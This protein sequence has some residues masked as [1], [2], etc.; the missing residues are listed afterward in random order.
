M[1]E[2]AEGSFTDDS[3]ISEY[4]YEAVYSL[5]AMDVISGRDTGAFDPKAFATREETAKIICGVIEFAVKE[6]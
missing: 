3:V 6:K 4:A 5:K 2:A 1:P